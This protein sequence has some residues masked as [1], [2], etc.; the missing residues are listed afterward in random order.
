MN[1]VIT[2]KSLD[3]N[4][5][6]TLTV[7]LINANPT[8][9]CVNDAYIIESR[10]EDIVAASVVIFV[11]KIAK[12]NIFTVASVNDVITSSTRENVISIRSS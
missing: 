2:I 10:V 4:A 1:K 9:H 3:E 6:L 11:T 12:K 7:D 5:A 8:I